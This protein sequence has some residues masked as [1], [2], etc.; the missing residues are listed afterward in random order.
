MLAKADGLALGFVGG[1]GTETLHRREA[2]CSLRRRAPGG[3]SFA[4]G[5]RV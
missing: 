2:G 5:S 3:P 1:S 4:G